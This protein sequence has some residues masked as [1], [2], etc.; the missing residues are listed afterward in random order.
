MDLGFE[1]KL[2]PDPMILTILSYVF[3][4]LH[5]SFLER[6]LPFSHLF[7]SHLLIKVCLRLCLYYKAFLDSINSSEL[8]CQEQAS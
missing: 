1:S 5:S 2:I 3:I 6:S 7:D 8:L 4:M